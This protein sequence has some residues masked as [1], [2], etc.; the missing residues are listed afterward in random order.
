MKFSNEP[1]LFEIAAG[2]AIEGRILSVVPYGNGHIHQT[3]RV[4]TTEKA[5][6]LQRL[7][8]LLFPEPEKLM[9]S[10]VGVCEHLRG[11]IL[12]RGGNPLR[13]TLTPVPTKTAGWLI[14]DSE[15]SWRVFRFIEDSVCHETIDDTDLFRKVGEAL[16]RF[17]SD[18]SD[19]DPG[20]LYVNF[21]G[22][23][24]T[25]AR[26]RQFL[27]AMEKAEKER[28]DGAGTEIIFVL[29]N[30]NLAHGLAEDLRDGILPLR[31]VHNDT[32]LNNVLFDGSSGRALAV[33]DFDTIMPGTPCHDFGDAIR[34]GCNLATEDEPDL[35]KVLFSIE[36]FRAFARGYLRGSRNFL[37]EAERLRLVSGALTITYENGLRFL[38][39]HLV[40]DRY[41]RID[42]PGQN[43]DRCRTQFRMLEAMKT[44]KP[45]LETIVED[46]YQK[47]ISLES[48]G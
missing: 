10:I 25:P 31:V 34:F 37:T 42:R 9:I 12:A 21:P 11:K 6:I 8:P 35:S 33:I 16:G 7:N 36:R 32:K 2:F 40:G 48:G 3:F 15:A 5:Y 46:E 45:R 18:L 20:R 17:T 38:T 27:E 4:V 19:Y 29:Q 13:E 24:D 22:F 44:L 14:R 28:I 1:R 47:I 43:L 39:D 23:H 30:E 26:F 41:Y